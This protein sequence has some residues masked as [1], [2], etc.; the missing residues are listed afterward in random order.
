[1]FET[2]QGGP[3]AAAL[4]IVV[5]YWSLSDSESA[6]PQVRALR[7]GLDLCGCA[8][9]SGGSDLFKAVMGISYNKCQMYNERSRTH[10]RVAGK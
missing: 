8:C 1:M 2:P 9:D 5:F 3:L 6:G 10:F 7:E 4:V